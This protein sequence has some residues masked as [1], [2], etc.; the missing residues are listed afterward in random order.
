MPTTQ[1]DPESGPQKAKRWPLV[2]ALVVI[3]ALATTLVVVLTT[4]RGAGTVPAPAPS[5]APVSSAPATPARTARGA[6]PKAIGQDAWMVTDSG[7][8][9]MRMQVT[10]IR[11]AKCA[12]YARPAAPGNRFLLVDMNITT[13]DDP[14]NLLAGFEVTAGWEFVDDQGRSSEAS[15]SAALNCGAAENPRQSFRPNRTYQVTA[16]VEV[17]EKMGGALVLQGTWE[18]RIDPA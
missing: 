13:R 8:E 12:S 18:Y 1:Q 2:A 3:L 15:T 9:V 6:I 7:T 10:A 5:A 4:I 16:T 17:P 14:E 11:P